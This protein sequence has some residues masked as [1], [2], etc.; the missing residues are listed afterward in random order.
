MQVNGELS[1]D[2]LKARIRIKAKSFGRGGKRGKKKKNRNEGI[3]G[4]NSVYIDHLWSRGSTE[5]IVPG[6]R[7]ACPERGNSRI[8]VRLRRLLPISAANPSLAS[9]RSSAES[10]FTPGI[11]R[12][13][14]ATSHQYL[15]DPCFSPIPGPI[16]GV[17]TFHRHGCS[18]RG[19]FRREVNVPTLRH[20]CL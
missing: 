10:C 18:D 5:S 8:L 16:F 2:Q 12:N 3:V 9:L 15:A 13:L 17:N 6:G 14:S 20:F 11:G 7:R 4:G 1:T 19:H